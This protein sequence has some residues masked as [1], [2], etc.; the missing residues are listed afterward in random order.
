VSFCTDGIETKLA[1]T[2]SFLSKC[3]Y[4]FANW[5][6]T[7]A[8][9]DH[10]NF[11]LGN[12]SFILFSWIGWIYLTKHGLDDG[13]VTHISV[14]IGWLAKMISITEFRS[15]LEPYQEVNK[16]SILETTNMIKPPH[17]HYFRSKGES[18][19][20]AKWAMFEDISCQGQNWLSDM[21]ILFD[22]YYF[23][24]LVGFW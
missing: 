9:R 20:S 13:W 4:C 7:M 3:C 24:F 18:E 2:S 11:C 10:I 15:I 16:R 22:L 8:T 1:Q 19:W 5:Q 12:I 6:T 17:A 14:C 23:T 21:I